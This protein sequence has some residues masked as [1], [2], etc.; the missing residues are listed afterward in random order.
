MY[1]VC[2]LLAV[3]LTVFAVVAVVNVVRRTSS[4]WRPTSTSEFTTFCVLTMPQKE[5]KEVEEDG[6]GK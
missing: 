2:A 1:V 6:D 4:E 5:N 3:L